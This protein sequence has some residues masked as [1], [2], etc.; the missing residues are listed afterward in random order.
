MANL[1]KKLYSKKLI[2]Q[3]TYVWRKVGIGN[4]IETERSKMAQKAI[5]TVRSEGTEMCF[6]VFEY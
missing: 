1:A 3:P 5:K 2:D 4:E 6:E